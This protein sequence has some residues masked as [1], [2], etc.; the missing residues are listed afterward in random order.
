MVEVGVGD[1]RVFT[2][3]EHALY[4]AAAGGLGDF[5][6]G[7]PFIGRQVFVGNL[8]KFRQLTSVLVVAHRD[9]AGVG[10]RRATYIGDTLHVVLAPGRV[11]AAVLPAHL[12]G[13]EH[14]VDQGVHIIGTVLGLAHTHSG[15]HHGG[16][17]P[18][19]QLCGLT[20]FFGRYAGDFGGTLGGVG[21]YLLL[22]RRK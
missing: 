1:C 5:D 22:Q 10:D 4:L 7:Q 16:F 20:Q 18:A 11:D 13:G 15:N 3:N 17:R 21:G 8:P 2:H 9:V 12:A 19:V 14:H 6:G